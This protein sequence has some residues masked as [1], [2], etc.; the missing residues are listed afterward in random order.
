MAAGELKVLLCSLTRLCLARFLLDLLKGR[1]VE[2]APS[3]SPNPAAQD[4]GKP[5]GE[6]VSWMAGGREP[7]GVTPSERR[8]RWDSPILTLDLGP[9]RSRSEPLEA[10]EQ[11]STPPRP[12]LHPGMA[13]IPPRRG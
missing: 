11:I 12:D 10:Q 6:E 2:S 3:G 8:M 13:Q 9:E 5:G 7:G 4:C 1:V